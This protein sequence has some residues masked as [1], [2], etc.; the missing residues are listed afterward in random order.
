MGGGE[1]YRID[2]GAN[3]T[4]AMVTVQTHRGTVGLRARLHRRGVDERHSW[5]PLASGIAY[6]WK[7]LISVAPT[8]SLHPDHADR[9]GAAV[10]DHRRGDRVLSYYAG[11]VTGSDGRPA[12][13]V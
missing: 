9:S 2:M 8:G 1:W 13:H 7:R 11:S 6:G 5:T 4:V 10:V 3:R 12:D